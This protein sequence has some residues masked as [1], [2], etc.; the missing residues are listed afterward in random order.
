MHIQRCTHSPV[1]TRSPAPRSPAGPMK[2]LWAQTVPQKP[3]VAACVVS[4]W[5]DLNLCPSVHVTWTK[6][7]VLTP[8]CT[9]SLHQPNE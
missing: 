6:S 7:L 8:A 3:T 1:H 4:I 5:S 2:I 9:R